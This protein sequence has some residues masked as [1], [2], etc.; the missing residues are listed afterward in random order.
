MSLN[1]NDIEKILKHANKVLID[2]YDAIHIN[3][4]DGV[5]TLVG[6][7]KIS[8][9]PTLIERIM[10]VKDFIEFENID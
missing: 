6:I 2:H 7:K 5:L 4:Y 10:S 3:I 9:E 1:I 8:Y